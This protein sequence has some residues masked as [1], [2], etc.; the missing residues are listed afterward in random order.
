MDCMCGV[1]V[2]PNTKKTKTDTRKKKGAQIRDCA[3]L[4]EEE[5]KEKNKL[6]T[7]RVQLGG[8]EGE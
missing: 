6:G 8:E 4:K 5:E 7:V 3:V 1:G 2:V